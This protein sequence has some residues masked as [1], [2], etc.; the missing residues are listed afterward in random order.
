MMSLRFLFGI[1]IQNT[2]CNFYAVISTE[3][4]YLCRR[5][6]RKNAGMTQT[7]L[8]LLPVPVKERIKRDRHK[9]Y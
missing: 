3:M 4:I 5:L 1:M 7:T 2:N 8:S 9:N 6:K